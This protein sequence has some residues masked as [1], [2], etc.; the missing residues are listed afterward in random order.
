MKNGSNDLKKKNHCRNVFLRADIFSFSM[1][2]N[3]GHNSSVL[4][5]VALRLAVLMQTFLF[6]VNKNND[7][8]LCSTFSVFLKP[9][10]M[11]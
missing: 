5:S 7:K 3:G 9:F 4:Q 6:R 11:N 10:S 1:P 8:L 2:C